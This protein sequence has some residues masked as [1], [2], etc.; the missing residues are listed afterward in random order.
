MEI[1]R[2]NPTQRWSDATVY[3][4]LIHFVEVPAVLNADM[5]GQ[6]KQVLAQA[7]ATLALGGS[8]KSR[9]LMATIYVTNL[10]KVPA[11]NAVWD[12]WLA[13]GSAPVR[14]CLKV[15]LINPGMLVEVP[16]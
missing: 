11:M 9:L 8:D 4:G 12:A 15:E 16:S 1:Q 6:V 7:E 14:A 3:Q 2:I 13:P 5:Q 10:A